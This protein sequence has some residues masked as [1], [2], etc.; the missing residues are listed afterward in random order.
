VATVTKS[1]PPPPV[2]RTIS[3]RSGATPQLDPV[4]RDTGMNRRAELADF[5]I[6]GC[7]VLPLRRPW[8]FGPLAAVAAM[9]PLL[10][11]QARRRAAWF[12]RR[13]PFAGAMARISSTGG[14]VR[15]HRPAS[16][17]ETGMDRH[18]RLADFF[19]AGCAILPLPILLT[20]G[21]AA[22]FLTMFVLLVVGCYHG[23]LEQ[24][25]SGE[26][27][28]YGHGLDGN[29]EPPNGPEAGRPR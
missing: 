18:A 17:K 9:V 14:R 24:A 6:A 5:F 27:P 25:E 12:T 11:G 22:A 26:G 1:R 29:R 16:S 3:R 4:F 15:A 10:L 23:A 21:P 19:L 2:S 8:N 20:F 13:G 28:L 7:A